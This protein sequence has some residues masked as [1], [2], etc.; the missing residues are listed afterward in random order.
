MTE[1]AQ[2]YSVNIAIAKEWLRF[3]M[4]NFW[5]GIS[6]AACFIYG[7]PGVGKTA[8]VQQLAD[9]F[10]AKLVIAPL[11][12]IIDPSDLRGFAVPIFE[13]KQVE[14]FKPSED[15]FPTNNVERGI[16]F[17]DELN[18]ATKEV[19]NAALQLVYTRTIGPHKL[20]ENYMI[21]A[22]GNSKKTFAFVHQLSEPLRSRFRIIHVHPD[23]DTWVKNFAVPN[24]IAS[25]IISFLKLYPSYFANYDYA[26][27]N[28]EM[29]FPC[30]RAWEMLSRD[31]GHAMKLNPE[32]RLAVFSSTVGI[33]AGTQFEAFIQNDALK[34]ML[35]LNAVY[36]KGIVPNIANSRQAVIAVSAI[37]QNAPL[38]DI[39]ALKNA[40]DVMHKIAW[41]KWDEKTTIPPKEL[42]VFGLSILVYRK[43]P[44]EKFWHIID[45]KKLK[46]VLEL[47][48][49][50][51]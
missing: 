51:T 15:L 36:T 46:D 14:W 16:L 25:E 47:L 38:N 21:V 50:K 1:T 26:K 24:N 3:N 5:K 42:M 28:P 11:H 23:F 18:C 12:L 8:I 7:P 41:T 35:D 20:G 6:K 2:E 44:M 27:L 48:D 31:L 40:V 13:K 19:L 49:I 32:V 34:M 10:N 37:A 29:P 43:L 33:S 17:L 4:V 22:A 45:N 30:P 39:K 9:E